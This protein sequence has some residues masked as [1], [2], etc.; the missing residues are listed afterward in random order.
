MHPAQIFLK[1][2]TMGRSRALS[3][4]ENREAR[5]VA[6]DGALGAPAVPLA[7]ATHTV[8]VKDALENIIRP[9]VLPALRQTVSDVRASEAGARVFVPIV[10]PLNMRAPGFSRDRV[11]VQDSEPLC[12]R[13]VR[14]RGGLL[15]LLSRGAPDLIA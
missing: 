13:Q 10:G 11:R 8:T 2:F 9:E 1:A 7:G 5:R 6:R 3:V 4:R 14:S 15:G 12:A